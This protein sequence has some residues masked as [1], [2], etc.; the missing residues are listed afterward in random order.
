M[1]REQLVLF[2]TA[3]YCLTMWTIVDDSALLKEPLLS[4]R[5]PLGCLSDGLV[6]VTFQ[7]RPLGWKKWMGI[8]GGHDAELFRTNEYVRGNDLICCYAWKND[9]GTTLE[10]SWQVLQTESSSV[11]I[12][13]LISVQDY[14]PG[15]TPVI[16]V[17]TT[18]TIQECLLLDAD[19]QRWSCFDRA[20]DPVPL[21]T[22]GCILCRQEDC[23]F[24]YLEMLHPADFGAG[25]LL[26]GKEQPVELS[27]TFQLVHDQLE[28]G[29]IRRSRL[30]GWIIP[31]DGD[32]QQAE[33]LFLRFRDAPCRLS[34]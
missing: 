17:G 4:A 20:A 29:V 32:Q 14:P 2:F 8:S 23:E 3:E 28:K 22:P 30:Q 31:R 19:S 18:V 10:S 11:G 34:S 27:W 26:A 5:L 7:G 21:E 12:E 13:L 9:R 6:D 25:E 24:S 15:E 1:G 16:S 33:A